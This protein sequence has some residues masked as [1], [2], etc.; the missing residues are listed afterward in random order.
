MFSRHTVTEEA[1]E[2]KLSFDHLLKVNFI[3]D[4]EIEGHDTYNLFIFLSRA[5]PGHPITAL[6]LEILRANKIASCS[7]PF[8]KS[9]KWQRG[10]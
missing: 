8:L 6:A 7:G 4:E 2:Q 3:T 9:P 10:V 1:P 5:V